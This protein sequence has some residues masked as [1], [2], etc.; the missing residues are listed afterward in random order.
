VLILCDSCVLILAFHFSPPL[1]R[2]CAILS[3]FGRVDFGRV[4]YSSI[5]FVD[6]GRVF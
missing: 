3:L 6:F 4:F 5:E 1:L 2:F